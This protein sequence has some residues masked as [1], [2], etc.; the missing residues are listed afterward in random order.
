MFR[1]PCRIERSPLRRQP[2]DHV[3]IALRRPAIALQSVEPPRLEPNVTQ[4]PL[5]DRGLIAD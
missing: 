4:I 1:R 3:A 2:R 5:V